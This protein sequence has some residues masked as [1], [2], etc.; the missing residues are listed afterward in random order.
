MQ[1]TK[2]YIVLRNSSH[3][4]ACGRHAP[5]KHASLQ[6]A[7]FRDHSDNLPCFVSSC[8]CLPRPMIFFYFQIE[9]AG[10][11]IH[12]RFP[13]SN[14]TD[15]F[16]RHSSGETSWILRSSM[17]CVERCTWPY[18][19]PCFVD[20]SYPDCVNHT[21]LNTCGEGA[22]ITDAEDTR[23]RVAKRRHTL[24]FVV[25]S[26]STLIL[27]LLLVTNASIS[28][29][30]VGRFFQL[31]FPATPQAVAIMED[32]DIS[33][34]PDDVVLPRPA[35]P[36]AKVDTTVQ[37]SSYLLKI[38]CVGKAFCFATDWLTHDIIWLLLL[39]RFKYVML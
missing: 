28:E 7:F 17:D 25:L 23:K 12:S 19:F 38:F 11:D 32:I 35:S 36:L 27:K 33:D 20:E 34:I 16:F 8:R 39:I 15:F 1:D 37:L 13:R 29:W 9:Y 24:L 6:Y 10:A 4:L 31:L 22:D 26:S 18:V 2:W 21:N 14:L 5:C 30:V 3:N